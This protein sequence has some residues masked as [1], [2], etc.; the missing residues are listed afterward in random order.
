RLGPVL[1]GFAPG[2]SLF[3]VY[4]GRRYKIG[5]DPFVIGRHPTCNLQIRDGN[6]S[7]KHAAIVQRFGIYYITDLG[8]LAGLEYRGMKI[9][10]KRIDEG[11]MFMVREYALRFTFHETDA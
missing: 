10:N 11:D 7:R 1:A 3:L 8:S 6:V 5:R 2:E 9:S 4:E